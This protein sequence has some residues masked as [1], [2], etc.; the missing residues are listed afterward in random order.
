MK[1]DFC[2]SSIRNTEIFI[3][4]FANEEECAMDFRKIVKYVAVAGLV[5]AIAFSPF[6]SAIVAA[7]AEEPTQEE[8]AEKARQ[9]RVERE[10]EELIA[11][12]TSPV[13]RTVAGTKSSL[14]GYYLAKKVKG[15]AF[16][17]TSF[18][19]SSFVKVTDTDIKKSS[20][21]YGVVQNVAAGLNATVGPCIDVSYGKMVNGNFAAGTDASAGS[22]SIGIPSNFR[23]ENATYSVVA[24]YA[25]GTYKVF[26]NISSDPNAVTVNVEQAT[27]PNV[28]YAVIRR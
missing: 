6:T 23:T 11:E 8:L 10:R 21:A 24:V 28:M 26:D 9:E 4:I 3:L 20:A 22:I 18:D 16:A 15:V 17:P 19:K 5:G 27:S 2:R 13:N 7:S 12:A 1:K 25:G 14:D